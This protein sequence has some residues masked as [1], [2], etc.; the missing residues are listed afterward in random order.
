[1]YIVHCINTGE[2]RV[3]LEAAQKGVGALFGNPCS[4]PNR[5]PPPNRPLQENV[6][7]WELIP[8]R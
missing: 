8:A 1:M 5:F 6:K 3:S 4:R 2:I 7:D